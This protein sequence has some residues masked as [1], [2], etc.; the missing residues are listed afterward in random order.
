M[1]SDSNLARLGSDICGSTFCDINLQHV[2]AVLRC[3]GL[4]HFYKGCVISIEH[5]S[6]K[7]VL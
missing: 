3:W 4:G 6:M 2:S 1:H 7:A 5:E